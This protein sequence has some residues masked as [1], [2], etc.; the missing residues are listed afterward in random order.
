MATEGPTF[1]EWLNSAE[2]TPNDE[3]DRAVLKAAFQFRQESE[4]DYATSRILGHF[5]LH[6]G[7]QLTASQVARLLGI[8]N[9]SVFRHRKL[10][11]KQVVEQIQHRMNG[12]PYGK[13]LPRHAGSIA[14][15]LFTHPEATR[16]TL[17]EFIGNTWGFRVSKVALWKFLKKFGLDQASLDAA[18]QGAIQEQEPSEIIESFDEPSTGGLVPAPSGEFFLQTRNT[19]APSCFGHKSSLG[20]PRLRSASRTNTVR[21]SAAS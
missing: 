6:C 10:S 17:L 11:S 8:S 18:R 14:E 16:D 19:P 7:V 1:D 15:F 12:R 21:L 3:E 5:L 4:G 13:L 9:R 20:S 2:V